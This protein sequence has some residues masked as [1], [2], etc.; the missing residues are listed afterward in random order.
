MANA[1]IKAG[2]AANSTAGDMN[3]AASA[4]W[5]GTQAAWAMA[6]AVNDIP[7]SK[8][9]YVNVQEAITGTVGVGGILPTPS[10]H[11]AGYRVPGYGGGDVH[12]A[13]LEGGEAVV[14]K[15]LTPAVAPFLKSHGVPGFEGG[16]IMGSDG[17]HASIGGGGGGGPQT[18]HVPVYIDGS[19]IAEAMVPYSAA[20]AGRYQVR[21]SGRATGQWGTGWKR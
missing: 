20:A 2:G 15:E 16:G 19:K 14:P 21:N 3:H 5:N 1:F 10:G 7:N 13:L 18:I 6:Q 9:V 11:A 12:P 4:M 17:S 8:N